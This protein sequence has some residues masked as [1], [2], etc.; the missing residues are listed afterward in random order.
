MCILRHI[1]LVS[2][3]RF[4]PSGRRRRAFSTHLFLDVGIA[5]AARPHAVHCVRDV[6]SRFAQAGVDGA[7][8]PAA[9][10]EAGDV[11]LVRAGEVVPADG[12]VR[13][14]A[15]HVLS[16]CVC[17]C[18]CLCARF[19]CRVVAGKCRSSLSRDLAGGIEVGTYIR[20]CN[21]MFTHLRHR[22]QRSPLRKEL[23]A[24]SLR[25]LRTT[26]GSVNEFQRTTFSKVLLT[27]RRRTRPRAPRSQAS[28]GRA[29]LR[30]SRSGR[31]RSSGKRGGFPPQRRPPAQDRPPALALG[32][33]PLVAAWGGATRFDTHRHRNFG[34]AGKG[35][36]RALT[37]SLS[38]SLLRAAS[39]VLPCCLRSW[40]SFSMYR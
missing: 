39:I 22:S 24:W 27:L 38:P 31:H 20:T 34:D 4:H 36:P 12:E 19:F 17:V 21:R 14:Q 33:P 11:I 28:L 9:E 32:E 7:A 5:S 1:A 3:S 10:L 13:S 37:P 16:V 15:S 6:F 18:M 2:Y 35:N 23:N 29:M 26:P 40:C 30:R 25:M 8:V